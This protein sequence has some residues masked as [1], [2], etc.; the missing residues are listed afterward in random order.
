[1]TMWPSG[2]RV[3]EAKVTV[4]YKAPKARSASRSS[5]GQCGWSGWS[6]VAEWEMRSE[7]LQETTSCRTPES[8]VGTQAFIF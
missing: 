2:E 1:M 7:W 6:G 4:K 5:G 8:T 3:V